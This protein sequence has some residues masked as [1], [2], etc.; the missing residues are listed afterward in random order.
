MKKKVIFIG[1]TA[2]SGSTF[3]D[4]TIA[5]DPL[6]FS[7]GEIQAYFNPWRPHHFHPRCSCGSPDCKFWTLWREVPQEDIYKAIFEHFPSLEFIVDSS[8]D[9]LWIK[10]QSEAVSKQGLEARHILIWKTPLEFASSYRKRKRAGS[11]YRQ[12]VNYHRIYMTLVPR[13][14]AIRYRSYAEGHETLAQVCD[15]LDIPY[16][17]GKEKFWEKTHH[18][19]FG[20]NSARVHLGTDNKASQNHRLMHGARS[21]VGH[22]TVY[23]RP[24]QDELLENQVREVE[25]R[26]RHIRLILTILAARDINGD[27]SPYERG[28]E[29]NALS[30][31]SMSPA[32]TRIRESKRILRS[33]I[34]RLRYGA[35]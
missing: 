16:F 31:I 28:D 5:N 6:G 34:A 12:W 25:R 33:L 24:V 30:S 22:Q 23:Y 14:G 2:Y 29:A 27:N 13:W 19:V 21:S 4:M 35:L 9:P 8:K 18:M 20:N 11:W 10:R 15:Y 17:R 7:L 26:S 3:F 32:S 1:G